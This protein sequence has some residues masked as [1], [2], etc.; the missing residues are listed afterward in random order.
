METNIPITPVDP[1]WNKLQLLSQDIE[2]HK[3]WKVSKT[4][5]VDLKDVAYIMGDN[6]VSHLILPTLRRHKLAVIWIVYVAYSLY[7]MYFWYGQWI[8]KY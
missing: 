2:P 4:G 3:E 1:S 7:W 5:G 8:F 6:N